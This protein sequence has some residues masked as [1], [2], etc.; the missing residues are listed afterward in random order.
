MDESILLDSIGT[1]KFTQSI[2]EE[3]TTWVQDEAGLNLSLGEGDSSIKTGSDRAMGAYSNEIGETQVD[4]LT[5]LFW[6][7]VRAPPLA[8][9]R[10]RLTRRL[11]RCSLIRSWCVPPR[12][13][14]TAIGSLS[15]GRLSVFLQDC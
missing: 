4:G 1:S 5:T 14:Q 6:S 10:V 11:V 7:K 15:N 12:L 9:P 3:A 2:L 13:L 8:Y